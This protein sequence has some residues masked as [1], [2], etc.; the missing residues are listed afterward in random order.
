MLQ[1]SPADSLEASEVERTA[2]KKPQGIDFANLWR[3]KKQ[4]QDLSSGSLVC[5]EPGQVKNCA[6]VK[7]AQA[8]RG[9]AGGT[10]EVLLRTVN[11]ILKLVANHCMMMFSF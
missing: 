10:L 8:G 1:L 7:A 4:D 11:F 9:Q 2:E 5:L 3:H 6:T